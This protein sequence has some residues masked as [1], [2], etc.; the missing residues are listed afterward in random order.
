MNYLKKKVNQL[1]YFESVAITALVLLSFY[2]GG[3]IHQVFLKA[4]ALLFLCFIATGVIILIERL[5]DTKTAFKKGINGEQKVWN[6]LQGLAPH[7]VFFK[8]LT[9]GP[10]T[11]DIDFLVIGPN[12]L[13]AIEAKEVTGKIEYDA[14]NKEITVNGFLQNYLSQARREARWAQ[15]R[16]GAS[17]GITFVRPILVFTAPGTRLLVNNKVDLVEILR[18]EDLEKFLRGAEP[19][20]VLSTEKQNDVVRKVSDMLNLKELPQRFAP[21]SISKFSLGEKSRF[22]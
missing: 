10:G 6:V 21:K 14:R 9:D 3:A 19:S 13:F 7:F 16:I 15:E 17:F 8:N 20:P 1:E 2:L 18:L 5:K 4:I 11:A 22:R 12:G